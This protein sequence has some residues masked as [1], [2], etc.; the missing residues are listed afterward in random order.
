MAEKYLRRGRDF[1]LA[2]AFASRLAAVGCSLCGV[3]AGFGQDMANTALQ[4]SQGLPPQ[5]PGLKQP[6]MMT[7]DGTMIQQP[8][9]ASSQGSD[10][11]QAN[12]TADGT[13]LPGGEGV[14]DGKEAD[15]DLGEQWMM[16]HNQLTLPFTAFADVSVFHT[17]NVALGHDHEL[18]DWFL[19]ATVG[20][21]YSHP[22]ANIWAVNVGI[23]QTFFRYDRF[24]EFD[25]NSFTVGAGLSVQAH[26]LWDT[27]WNL[28]YSFNRLTDSAASGQ[29]FSG[30]AIVLSG[31][32]ALK[33][34]SA[35]NLLFGVVGSYDFADPSSLQRA[36]VAAFGSYSVNLTRH[37]VVGA[38]LREAFL[39][40][41]DGSRRDFVHSAALTARYNFNKWFSLSASVAGTINQ[42]NETPFDYKVLNVGVGLSGNIQF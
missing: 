33:L 26:P 31:A 16:K 21:A 20:A 1:L 38:T 15:E 12:V 2:I 18:S 22:F 17:S 13:A 14:S 3:T 39:A 10:S 30:H 42:S 29:L 34:S 7:A 36:D 35:D 19:V 4:Q 40:Y 27:V 8:E 5:V 24:G 6:V 25:F 32:K 11:K 23:S 9:T 37:V 28:Q 41:V